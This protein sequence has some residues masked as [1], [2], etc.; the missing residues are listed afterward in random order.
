MNPQLWLAGLVVLFVAYWP[1]VAV[2]TVLVLGPLLGFVVV[3]V[4]GAI[5]TA[6]APHREDEEES[7]DAEELFSS[8]AQNRND[9]I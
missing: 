7:T 6:V 9:S 5:R 1:V 8:L 3:A 4:V 2:V